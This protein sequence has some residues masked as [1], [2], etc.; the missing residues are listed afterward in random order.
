MRAQ[1]M[2]KL[3]AVEMRNA[4]LGN[5]LKEL[6]PKILLRFHWFVVKLCKCGF[7]EARSTFHNCSDTNAVPFCSRCRCW[8]SAVCTVLVTINSS[9]NQSNLCI[10]RMCMPLQCTAMISSSWPFLWLKQE[11]NGSGWKTVE[12]FL[13]VSQLA[14]LNI[15]LLTNFLQLLY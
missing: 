6:S 11:H 12:S 1:M 8:S 15:S 9:I 7:L 4:I 3:C 2:Q 13:H 5:H 10:A 14:D